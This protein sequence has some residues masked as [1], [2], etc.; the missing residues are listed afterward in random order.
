M[1]VTCI[2]MVVDQQGT[3]RYV[4]PGRSMNHIEAFIVGKIK[5]IKAYFIEALIEP[6]WSEWIMQPV[7]DYINSLDIQN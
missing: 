3:L 4:C 7:T 6:V 1:F 2:P 5:I